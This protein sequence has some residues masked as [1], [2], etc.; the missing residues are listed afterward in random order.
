MQGNNPVSIKIFE[1]NFIRFIDKHF[2]FKL[3]ANF[4]KKIYSIFFKQVIF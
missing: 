2:S 1:I 3:I 4:E